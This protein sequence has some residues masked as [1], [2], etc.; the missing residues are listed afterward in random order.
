MD[1]FASRLNIII[2]ENLA[3]MISATKGPRT[4]NNTIVV[5]EGY[6]T[7]RSCGFYEDINAPSKP[8]GRLSVWSTMTRV[9]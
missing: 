2:I 5:A 9:L 1:S 4:L 7:S 3:S 8:Q 6:Q